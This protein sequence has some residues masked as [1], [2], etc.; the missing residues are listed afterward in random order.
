M[1]TCNEGFGECIEPLIF[2]LD[3]HDS[4]TQCFV[5]NCHPV[6]EGETT[7]PLLISELFHSSLQRVHYSWLK[8]NHGNHPKMQILN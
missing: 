6:M 2:Q 7:A 5:A 8:K 1:T 3:H 4:R